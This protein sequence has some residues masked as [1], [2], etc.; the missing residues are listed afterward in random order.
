MFENN[1]NDETVDF[2]ALERIETG[3][4]IFVNYNGDPDDQGPLWFDVW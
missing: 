2:F 4:E 3:E 1:L